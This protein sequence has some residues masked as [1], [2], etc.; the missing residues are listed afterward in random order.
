[1]FVMSRSD[2]KKYEDIQIGDFKFTALIDTSSDLTF[3]IYNEYVKIISP[4]LNERQIS[5]EGLGS[6]DN[7]FV[8]SNLRKLQVPSFRQLGSILKLSAISDPAY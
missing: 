1:M 2:K 5:F 3:I 4:I 8:I 7:K 6:I